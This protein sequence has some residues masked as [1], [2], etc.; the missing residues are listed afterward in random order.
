MY[1]QFVLKSYQEWAALL[2][3]S[4]Q[5]PKPRPYYSFRGIGAD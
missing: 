1:A 3:S 5:K 2:S 4:I